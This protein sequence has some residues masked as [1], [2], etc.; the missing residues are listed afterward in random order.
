MPPNAIASSVCWLHGHPMARV[1]YLYAQFRDGAAMSHVTK[2]CMHT[3]RNLTHLGGRVS[4]RESAQHAHSCTHQRQIAATVAT[5]DCSRRHFH[6]PRHLPANKIIKKGPNVTV[7]QRGNATHAKRCRPT[8]L[9]PSCHCRNAHAARCQYGWASARRSNSHA[10]NAATHSPDAPLLA[11][12]PAV[13][14]SAFA[15]ASSAAAASCVNV[16]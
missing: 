16:V 12:A 15:D 6:H 8:A 5:V 10:A 2:R 4:M 1:H 9:L 11:S 3:E 14:K 7:L 13:A